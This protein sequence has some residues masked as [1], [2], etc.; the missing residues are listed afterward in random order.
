MTDSQTTEVSR[1]SPIG[2]EHDFKGW[3]NFEDGTG[4]EQVCRHCGLG[5][6]AWSLHQADIWE[7]RK[8]RRG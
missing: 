5:A 6:M 8:L 4:G 3:R 7:E 2:C 1:R